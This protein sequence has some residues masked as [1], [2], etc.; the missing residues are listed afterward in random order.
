M[1][2]I[3]NGN[4]SCISTSIFGGGNS[5]WKLIA[6][7]NTF[8]FEVCISGAGQDIALQVELP[9]EQTLKLLNII[10]DINNDRLDRYKNDNDV[11][12]T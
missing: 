9:N 10:K 2:R 8:I 3:H 11:I 5:E 1:I 4:D 12:I 6:K 7:S